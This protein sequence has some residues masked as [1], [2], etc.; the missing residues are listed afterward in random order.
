MNTIDSAKSLTP[1]SW[2]GRLRCFLDPHR[3]ALHIV[4]SWEVS[5]ASPIVSQEYFACI[6]DKTSKKVQW[7]ISLD[8][9]LPFIRGWVEFFLWESELPIGEEIAQ[10]IIDYLRLFPG[11][12]ML[13]KSHGFTHS[14]VPWI[15]PLDTE[16]TFIHPENL[17]SWDI[18]VCLDK[19]SRIIYSVLYLGDWYVIS[20]QLGQAGLMIQK[21]S[22]LKIYSWAHTVQ[23][24]V[25]KNHLIVR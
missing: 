1:I 11:D 6:F 25:I 24:V 20:K 4:L 5:K 7:A 16:F 3:Y 23:K 14:I 13:Y 10:W 15:L 8:E 2:M 19:E 17:S 12:R 9:R 18:V 22:D 21:I